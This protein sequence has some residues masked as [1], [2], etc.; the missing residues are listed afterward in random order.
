MINR[1][2]I[3]GAKLTGSVVFLPHHV[4]IVLPPK[5]TFIEDASCYDIFPLD[6]VAANTLRVGM[7]CG[8]RSDFKLVRCDRVGT[9]LSV[10]SKVFLFGSGAQYRAF[11][12]RSEP[13]LSPSE[14]EYCISAHERLRISCAR[15]RVDVTIIKRGGKVEI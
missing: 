8:D 13:N 5:S 2:E 6:T 4:K 15:N 10:A 11:L 12:A 9:L 7:L 1:D 3:C 14:I